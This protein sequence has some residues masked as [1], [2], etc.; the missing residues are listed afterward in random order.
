MPFNN[1][2][3]LVKIN[4]ISYISRQHKIL[5]TGLDKKE[6]SLECTLAKQPGSENKNVPSKN[7]F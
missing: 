6:K 4:F 2:M 3:D 1:Q 7:I 5:I